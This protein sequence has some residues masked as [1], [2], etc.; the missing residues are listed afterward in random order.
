MVTTITLPAHLHIQI[1]GELTEK[2]REELTRP[3]VNLWVVDARDVVKVDG[4]GLQWWIAL[5][6][7]FGRMECASDVLISPWFEA[8]LTHWHAPIGP[9]KA[10]Q[11]GVS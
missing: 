6:K 2:V 10:A 7:E 3:G 4:A 5:M 11:K 9:V 8:E 1:L